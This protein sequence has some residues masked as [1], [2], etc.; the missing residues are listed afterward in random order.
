[1]GKYELDLYA[2]YLLNAWGHATTTGLY[3]SEL[4]LPDR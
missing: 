4:K 3:P 2:D 1:M